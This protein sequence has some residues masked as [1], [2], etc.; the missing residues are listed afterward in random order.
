MNDLFPDLPPKIIELEQRTPEWHA[1]RRGEDLPDK[2]PRIT[3]SMVPQIIGV[4]PWG[5]AYDLWLELTG[6]KAGKV[7]NFAMQRG[8]DMEPAAR[9]A[10]T[11][12]TGIEVRDICVE[13]PTIPW[14]AASLDGYSMFGDTLSEIKCPGAKDHATALLGLIPDKYIP[15]VQWQLFNCPPAKVNDYWSYDGSNGLLVKGFPDRKY[16]EFLYRVSLQFRQ[17]VIDDVPP[18]GEEFAYLALQIRELYVAKNAAEEAYK[19]ATSKLTVLVPEYARSA[20]FGGV[21][22]S[23]SESDGRIDYKAMVEGLKITADDVE[24]YRKAGKGESYRVT[25][26]LDAVVPELGKKPESESSVDDPVPEINDEVAST[27]W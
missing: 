20:S 10:Y 13:H 21:T 7:S 6:R 2:G 15:Q 26:T 24:K 22:V 17:S 8:I 1:W 25:V 12:E 4:S 5:S 19:E 14:V 11:V 16:Q 9:A 27:A 3:A 23:R 18:D